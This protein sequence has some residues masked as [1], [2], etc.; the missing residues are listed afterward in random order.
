M[1]RTLLRRSIGA[2]LGVSCGVAVALAPALAARPGPSGAAEA[3]VSGYGVSAVS[4]DLAGT[5]VAAVSFRLDPPAASTL[6]V[7]LG[8]TWTSC[9]ATAGRATCTFDRPP[10]LGSAHALMV[11]AAG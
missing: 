2:L 7:S 11:V 8:T 6:R 10:P 4:Y 9:T 3:K 1:R 5:R